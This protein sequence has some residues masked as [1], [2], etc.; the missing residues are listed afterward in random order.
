MPVNFI[1]SFIYALWQKNENLPA[2]VFKAQIDPTT[3]L[4]KDIRAVR[5]EEDL[6]NMN[7]KKGYRPYLR[8]IESS[9]ACEI[10]INNI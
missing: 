3:M 1:P 10:K 4:W 7:L 6:P 5:T 9:V 8:P 2:S